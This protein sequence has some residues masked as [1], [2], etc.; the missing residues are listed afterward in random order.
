MAT[1]TCRRRRHSPSSRHTSFAFGALLNPQEHVGNG[2]WAICLRSR[3][4]R[5][6]GAAVVG[7]GPIRLHHSLIKKG[8]HQPCLKMS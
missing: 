5:I 7:F 3:M 4:L 8:M 6:Q 2:R 1:R